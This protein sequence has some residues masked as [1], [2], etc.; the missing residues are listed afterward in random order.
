MYAINHRNEVISINPNCHFLAFEKCW[1]PLMP[2][3]MENPLEMGMYSI[4]TNERFKAPFVW[5]NVKIVSIETDK[6]REGYSRGYFPNIQQSDVYR[7]EVI[8]YP[9]HYWDD[10]EYKKYPHKSF[11]HTFYVKNGLFFFLDSVLKTI[12]G[13]INKGCSI[14]TI[15]FDFFDEQCEKWNFLA[16]NDQPRPHFEFPPECYPS[17]YYSLIEEM[18][19]VVYED[20]IGQRNGDVVWKEADITLKTVDD[21][22]ID[23]VSKGLMKYKELNHTKYEDEKKTLFSFRFDEERDENSCCR[24]YS[25][26]LVNT[27]TMDKIKRRFI[28]E[29]I[30]DGLSFMFKTSAIDYYST[31][32]SK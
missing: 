31:R 22:V 6:T 3:I 10:V 12:N 15:N 4:E 18:E 5:E 16:A 14:D 24:S 2:Y 29:L 9:Y 19:I 30:V 11:T 13:L 8:I 26:L 27:L 17:G 28:K 20:G 25:K 7:I 21:Y 23:L 32:H 1:A